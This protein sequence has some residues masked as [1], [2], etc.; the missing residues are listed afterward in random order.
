MK[1]RKWVICQIIYIYIYESHVENSMPSN[2]GNEHSH[3]KEFYRND[4]DSNISVYNGQ[5]YYIKSSYGSKSYLCSSDMI[6]D[7]IKIVAEIKEEYNYSNI[8]TNATGIYLYYAGDYDRL[9]VQHF[10]FE[11]KLIAECQEE[12]EGGYEEG[13][14]V[15]NIY[16][17]DKNCEY[18]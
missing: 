12:Y 8:H 10:D 6:G 17:Y 14:S 13:H 1:R 7:N 5:I 9:R 18:I 3:G 2:P 15:S 4:V 16:F 11:G